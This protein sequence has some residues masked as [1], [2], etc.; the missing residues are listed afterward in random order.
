MDTKTVSIVKD[1]RYQ[2]L[3]TFFGETHKNNEFVCFFLHLINL[4]QRLMQLSVIN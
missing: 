4:V 3:A 2:Y 1:Y